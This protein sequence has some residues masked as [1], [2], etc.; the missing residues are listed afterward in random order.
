MSA[1]RNPVGP[2]EALYVKELGSGDAAVYRRRVQECLGAKSELNY[3][4]DRS[5]GSCTVAVKPD[6][7]GVWFIDKYGPDWG[8]EECPQENDLP[9]GRWTQSWCEV[10]D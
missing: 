8:L 10:V 5:G 3:P 2:G 6:S 1:I 9:F 7:L 4:S